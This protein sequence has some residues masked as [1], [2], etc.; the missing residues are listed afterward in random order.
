[1]SFFQGSHRSGGFGSWGKPSGIFV[2]AVGGQSGNPLTCGGRPSYSSGQS[3]SNVNNFSAVNTSGGS[4][5]GG[6]ALGRP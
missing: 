6:R 1:M 3:N 4:L 5:G 2:M